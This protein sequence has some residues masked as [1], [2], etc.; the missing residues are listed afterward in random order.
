MVCERTPVELFIHSEGK[1]E[2]RVVVVDDD[3]SLGN[4][5][6][7]LGLAGGADEMHVFLG[8]ATDLLDAGLGEDDG[9]SS[10]EP[11]E[12]MLPARE[13]GRGGFGHVHC[14]RC[15]RVVVTVQYRSRCQRRR[16]SP[17]T[18]VETLLEWAKRIFGLSGCDA[19]ALALRICGDDAN[20][21][22]NEHVG[23]LTRAPECSVC[24]DLVPEPK[25]QG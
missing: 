1:R 15:R 20:L 5:L 10:H 4:V 2:P 22:G 21:S 16:V 12:R 7:D 13:A 3:R 24:F 19:E 18:T 9:E 6:D 8:E 17:A 14:H 25:M 23:E 11:V